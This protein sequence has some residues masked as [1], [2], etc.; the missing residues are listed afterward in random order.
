MNGS[1]SWRHQALVEVRALKFVWF[2]GAAGAREVS[3][4]RSF[5]AIY[6]AYVGFVWRVVRGMGVSE[7]HAPD[8]VQDVF[9]V[10]HRRLPEFDFACSVKTWLFEI[11][12]RVACDARR[13]SAR[14]RQ[15]E[16]LSDQLVAGAAGPDENTERLH[17]SRLLSELLE[18]MPNERRMVLICA[19]VEGLSGPEIAELTGLPLNTVYSRLR[20]ARLE[21]S[22]ALARYGWS[23]P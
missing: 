23:Y 5:E 8:A 22:E 16:P 7:Q 10:V 14:A 17:S 19:D 12:Y 1:R 11:T 15:S 9:V 18:Q 2:Q 20:R 3:D 6:A 21:L 13:K 4:A